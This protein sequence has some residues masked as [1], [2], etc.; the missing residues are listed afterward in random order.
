LQKVEWILLT[1]YVKF[2]TSETIKIETIY[3]MK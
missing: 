2:E 3:K 1:I